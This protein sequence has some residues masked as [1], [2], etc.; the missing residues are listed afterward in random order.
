MNKV[1]ELIEKFC[2]EGVEY[3]MLGEVV[4]TITT[5]KLNANSM[6]K[7]GIYP[8]YTCDATPYR[9]NTYSFDVDAILIS[10]NGSQVGHINHYK[11]KFDAYQRTYVLYDFNN[12]TTL[13]YIYVYLKGYLKNYI[14]KNC[15]KG[16]V[17][18]ITLP[19]LQSFSIPI[20]PL[21]IQE[22]IVKILD[23]FSSLTAELQAELQARKSQ[24]EFYRNELLTFDREDAD[25]SSL[26]SDVSTSSLKESEHPNTTNS[27]DN[28]RV[29]TT[30]GKP[31]KVKW[32]RL[33]DVGTFIR[34]NRSEE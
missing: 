14:L 3:K 12:I 1:E 16:S 25:T 23:S 15:K 10:G 20:P 29:T 21:P 5:G 22:A 24:Y 4:N 30:I 7:D 27:Q 11:G 6:D 8:F 34:G 18:Y 19:M 17:P 13:P 26:L 9:I 2:P 31:R 32:M 33:G 28:P